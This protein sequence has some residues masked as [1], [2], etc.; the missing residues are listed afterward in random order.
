MGKPLVI[1]GIDVLPGTNVD[2]SLKIARLPTHT[3]IE[4]PVYVMRGIEDGPVLLVTSSLHGDEVNGTET[5][6]RMI[7]NKSLIP[8]KGT[9]IVMPV[10]N[11]YGFLLQT[12]ALPDGKDLNR[13]FP[14]TKGGSLASRL[15]HIMLTHIVQHIDFGIDL[16]TGGARRTNF[17]Q[18]RCDFERKEVL[19]LANAFGAPFLINSKEIPGSFRRSATKLGKAM[20]VFEGGE[21]QR[22]DEPSIC[23]A[24][25]GIRRV[26]AHLGMV[27][28]SISPNKSIILAKSTWIRAR[29]SGMFI[30]FVISGEKVAKGQVIA[31]LGDPFGE[32]TFGI[33]AP[34]DGY[35]IGLNN[36]PVINAGDAVLHIG[37]EK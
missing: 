11:V 32:T 37:I 21:S 26:M 36:Q 6:R 5:L 18:V 35:I 15:A 10:V 24:M 34:F 19:D 2:I 14:G 27:E 33:K 13:S 12:R 4:L 30:P 29:I 28:D 31:Q 17:P 25:E 3:E 1:N 7:R 22:F 23:G 16:H 9:V 8:Q 20:I